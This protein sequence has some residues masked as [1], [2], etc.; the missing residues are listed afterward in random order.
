METFERE[1]RYIVLKR[2]HLASLP[3]DL[4][5][6]LKPALEDAAQLLPKFDCVVVEKGWP[7]FEPTWQ[8][9]ELRVNG[10]TTWSGALMPRPG[11]KVEIRNPKIGSE[12][13]EAIIHFAA[14]NVVVWDWAG[15]PAVNGLCAAYAHDIEMRPARTAEQIADDERAKAAIEMAGVIGGV[16]SMRDQEIL[17]ALAL[18]GYRKPVAP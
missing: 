9:I 10:A 12:W 8:A 15:E 13:S 3:N 18:A 2:K 7:E 4:Q 14:R 5:I 1:N 6:R 17:N 16:E 11:D